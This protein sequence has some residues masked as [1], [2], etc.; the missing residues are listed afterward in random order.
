[1][2]GARSAPVLPSWM[3]GVPHALAAGSL[4]QFLASGGGR[5]VHWGTAAWGPYESTCLLP[6]FQGY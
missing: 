5:H 6:Q 2:T 4:G 1:M 3:P